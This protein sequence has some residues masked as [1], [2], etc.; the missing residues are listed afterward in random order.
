MYRRYTIHRDGDLLVE[1]LDASGKVIDPEPVPAEDRLPVEVTVM[2]PDTA[3][4]KAQLL[5]LL[6]LAYG[7]E[8]DDGG[9]APPDPS[10]RRR[11]VLRS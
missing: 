4:A 7:I 9:E 6:E 3:E 8:A 2:G 10:K 11:N 5:D 1:E